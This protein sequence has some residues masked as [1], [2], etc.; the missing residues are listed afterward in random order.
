[1]GGNFWKLGRMLRDE[2]LLRETAVREC[3]EARA[4]GEYRIP[5]YF[6][7]K[8]DF[9]DMDV[10]V[11][12]AVLQRDPNFLA[13]LF[14]DLGIVDYKANGAVTT[15]VFRGLQTDFFLVPPC[16]VDTTYTFM[17]F[18]EVGNILGRLGRRFKL[19][20]GI[21]GLNYVFRWGD[22][23]KQEF[24]VTRDFAAICDLFGLDH[25]TWVRGFATR[26]EMFRW[27]TASPWFSARPYIDPESPMVQRAGVRPGIAAFIEFVKVN[28][29]AD[30]GAYIADPV[31]WVEAKFPEARLPE[32]LAKQVEKTDR[33]A[34]VSEKFSGRLVMEFRPGLEGRELGEFIRQFRLSKDDFQAYVLAT[35]AEQIREDIRT[36]VPVVE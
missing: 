35:S 2:Y 24:T 26:E 18:G 36:F 15:T 27:V 16:N 14:A 8:L 20:F 25:S 21:D 6:E 17:C 19:K 13:R 34:A 12:K 7:D 29:P 33:L 10:I 22:H 23:Y 28:V 31:A 5:R 30:A 4:P 9:G 1:M 3:L 32:K 11:S